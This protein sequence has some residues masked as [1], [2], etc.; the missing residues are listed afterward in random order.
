MTYSRLFQIKSIVKAVYDGHATQ[1]DPVIPD[2]VHEYGNALL[3]LHPPASVSP[4]LQ[5]YQTDVLNI[6]FPP[7]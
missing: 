1:G 3:A 4:L 2:L 6:F 5:T 7:R